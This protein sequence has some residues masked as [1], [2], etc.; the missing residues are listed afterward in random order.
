VHQLADAV[1]LFVLPLTF[2]I[3][4]VNL[5]FKLPLNR[6][7]KYLLIC[8]LAFAAFLASCSGSKTC[9]VNALVTSLEPG[10]ITEVMVPMRD[11][12]NLATDVYLPS[13][14]VPFPAILIRLPYGKSGAGLSGAVGG[15]MANV[16]RGAGYAVVIQDTRGR[17]RSEGEWYPLKYESE[18]GIDTVRWVEAQP[19]FNGSLGMAGG[20]YFGY[21][22]LAVSWQKPASLK[23]IAPMIT[24]SS[25]Y[26]LLFH[27]GLPRADLTINWALTMREKDEEVMV[28]ESTFIEAAT[29]WPLIEGDNATGGNLTWLDDWLQHPLDDSCYDYIPKN[30]IELTEVPMFMVSGWFDIFEETQLDDFE[31]AQARPGAGGRDRIIVGPWTHSIGVAESHDLEF[32][33]GSNFPASFQLMIDWFDALLK[34]GTPPSN[35]GPVRVYDPGKDVWLDRPALWSAGR[36]PFRLYLE[37]TQAATACGTP[38]RLETSLPA[39]S[40]AISYTYNPL[41]PIVNVGGSILVPSRAG[42]REQADLCQRG[43]VVSFESEPFAEAVTWEGRAVLTLPVS[44][45]APDTAFIARIS[46]VRPDGKFYNLREGSMTLSHREGDEDTASYT[47]GDVVILQ[48]EFAPLLWTLQPGEALR[49]EIMSSSLPALVQH[50]NVAHDWFMTAAPLPADQTLHLST[51]N[52]A[53]LEI[54]AL[55]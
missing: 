8:F 36:S 54:P 42:C 26:H 41:N 17:F 22:Q 45:S 50:P 14:T 38:G 35:W 33:H 4:L 20:S 48:I 6:V 24:P 7:K 23:A 2:N 46:L 55:Q 25:S 3:Y 34:G 9:D 47:P 44:S 51:D 49:L 19:W 29:H 5:S 52:P 32:P 16:F 37:G 30:V 11:C 40:S 43:D 1:F 18:D 28:P 31:K 15:L 10:T 13:G 21:T 53:Y 39:A 12:I 27:H